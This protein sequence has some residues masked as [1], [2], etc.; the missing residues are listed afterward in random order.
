MD[1]DFEFGV[2]GTRQV[3]YKQGSELTGEYGGGDRDKQMVRH[4]KLPV[5]RSR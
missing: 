3:W 2:P 5:A 4:I 1:R